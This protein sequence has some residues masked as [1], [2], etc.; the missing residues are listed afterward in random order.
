MA[1]EARSDTLSPE[2]GYRLRRRQ[3]PPIRERC[4]AALVVS[5]EKRRL[6]VLFGL[7]GAGKTFLARRLGKAGF[8]VCD[9]DEELP[10]DMRDAI[11]HARPVRADMRERFM[12]ALRRRVGTLWRQHP[13]LVVAQTFLKQ[14]HR[15]AFLRRFPR[16][17]FIL[18]TA[19]ARIRAI[20]LARRRSSMLDPR[21]AHQMA[22]AFDPPELPHR[23]L[24][25][26]RDHRKLE[27][28]LT[29]IINR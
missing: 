16:A 29:A 24:S 13:R 27:R 1:D 5:P 21:Y 9:G 8:H 3:G 23:R 19:N 25:N 28:G 12:A 11:A 20:R 26:N 17:E 6:L 2:T 18:I 7:P 22:K 14:A 4:D 15:S 10:Q